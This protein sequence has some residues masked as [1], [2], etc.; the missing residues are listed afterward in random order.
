MVCVGGLCWEDLYV[1]FCG[2]VWSQK[3]EKYLDV[4]LDSSSSLDFLALEGQHGVVS[5]RGKKMLA[6]LKKEKE[7]EKIEKEK[8]K[9]NKRRKNKKQ[10]N[11]KHT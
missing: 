7:K 2:G 3:E 9:E 6:I 11:K 5:L 10:K 8:E 1:W 4:L